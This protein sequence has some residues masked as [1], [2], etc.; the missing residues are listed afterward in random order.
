MYNDSDNKQP[1]IIKDAKGKRPEFYQN[2]SDQLMSMLMVLASEIN[3]LRDRVD[4]QERVAKQKGL[5]L[6]K[7]IEELELDDTALRE[8]EAWRQGF[9]D[10]LFYLARKETN[11]QQNQQ[12]EQAYRDIIEDIALK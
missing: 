9:F 4:A 6:A 5:D 12:T 10:R 3:V 1:Q 11:E 2:D 8:R 7:G